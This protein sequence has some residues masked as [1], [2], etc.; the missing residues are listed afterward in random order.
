MTRAYAV[1]LAPEGVT[2]NA[3]APGL[4]DT[5]MDKRLIKAGV[6]TRITV[7]RAG[8]ADEITNAGMF[9]VH[10]SYYGP[11]TRRDLHCALPDQNTLS[12]YYSEISRHRTHR[13]TVARP[14]PFSGLLYQIISVELLS[15]GIHLQKMTLGPTIKNG[16]RT[17]QRFT[18][19]A[20]SVLDMWP[21]AHLDLANDKTMTFQIPQSLREYFLRNPFDLA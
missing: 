11:D 2:L 15:R 1:R 9:L 12:P 5:E 8:T 13:K 7:G 16:Q 17:S 4:I 14:T 19:R 20:Q 18:Q 6:A 10:N 3:I 21:H